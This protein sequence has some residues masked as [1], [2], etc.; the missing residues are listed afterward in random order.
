MRDNP[1]TFTFHSL[2]RSSA[3]ALADQGAL[4][5]QL[6]NFYGWANSSLPQEYVSS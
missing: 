4:E 3:T 1:E 5:S 6:M 2:H